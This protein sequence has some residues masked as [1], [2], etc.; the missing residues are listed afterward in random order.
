M[1]RLK[2]FNFFWS[3][4]FLFYI[5]VIVKV[6]FSSLL[7]NLVCLCCCQNLV[8]I[9]IVKISFPCYCQNLVFT[10]IIKVLFILLLSKLFLTIIVKSR[11]PCYSQSR[12]P[13]YCRLVFR[14]CLKSCF[15]IIVKSPFPCYCQSRFPCYCQNLF[16]C[17]IIKILFFMKLKED[18]RCKMLYWKCHFCVF[19]SR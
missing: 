16:L 12:F 10:I 15:T 2:F 4:S 7:K 17:V 18:A 6:S 19:V 1:F 11:F 3:L 14:Y 9:A 13:C 8:F 5:P